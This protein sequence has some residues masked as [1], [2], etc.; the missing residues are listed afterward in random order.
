MSVPRKSIFF[1]DDSQSIRALFVFKRRRRIYHDQGW[2]IIALKI[3]VLLC[4]IKYSII[5]TENSLNISYL[6][7]TTYERL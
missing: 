6:S 3:T 7:R 1:P 4:A 5:T 2:D